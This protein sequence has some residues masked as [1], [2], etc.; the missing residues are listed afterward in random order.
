MI[1]LASSNKLIYPQF[2][3]SF[4]IFFVP[5]LFSKNVDRDFNAD[6]KLSIKELTEDI[7]EIEFPKPNIYL[8]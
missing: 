7:F 3:K 6:N 2:L 5:P 8:K 4:K 1:I